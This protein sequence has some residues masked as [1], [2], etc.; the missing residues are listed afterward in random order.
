MDRPSIFPLDPPRGREVLERLGVVS[1]SA[2]LT[3][4]ALSNHNGAFH[5]QDQP[6]APPFDRTS[7]SGSAALTVEASVEPLRAVSGSAELTVEAIV[8]PLLHCSK[9]N[10]LC[11]FALDRP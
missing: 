1:G 6:T 3:V 8:E 7:A 5:F 2:A 11:A 4:E 9:A 10:A